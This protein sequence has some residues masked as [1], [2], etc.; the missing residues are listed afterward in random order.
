MRISISL[1][2]MLS[3]EVPVSEGYESHQTFYHRAP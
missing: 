1:A 3:I 2:P